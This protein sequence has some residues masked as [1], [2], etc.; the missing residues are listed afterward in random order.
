MIELFGRAKVDWAIDSVASVP[1]EAFLFIV[2]N[3]IGRLS[4]RVS[5]GLLHAGRHPTML[6]DYTNITG[7]VSGAVFGGD[8]AFQR[9]RQSSQNGDAAPNAA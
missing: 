5:R 2:A 4:Q 8:I 9:R 6:P 3:Q 7:H 1:E